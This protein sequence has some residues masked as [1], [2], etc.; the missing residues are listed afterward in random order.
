M[1]DIR[2]FYATEINATI[3]L[4]SLA[5]SSNLLAGRQ[6]SEIDNR[7]ALNLD[8]LVSGKTTTGASPTTGRP[9]EIWAV[10]A[11]DNAAP[12]YLGGF[13]T[14]DA[15]SPTLIQEN[16]NIMCVLVASI[17]CNATSNQQYD[18]GPVSI[19]ALFGGFCPARFVFFVTQNTAVALNSTA[20]NH[21][22]RL[23][24]VYETA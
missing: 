23:L 14:A 5:S 16:K 13:G 8:Y 10:G 3:T 4:A 9:I 18:F 1:P 17:T 20:G 19:A 6:S 7:T 15:A 21:Q 24:P 2:P 22:I 11:L 12:T